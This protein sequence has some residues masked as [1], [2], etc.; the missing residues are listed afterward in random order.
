M[1]MLFLHGGGDAQQ[2]RSAIFGRFVQAATV[3]GS[4]RLA[5]VVAEDTEAQAHT[6]FE[7]YRAIFAALPITPIHIRPLFISAAQP[8]T[9]AQL[10]QI[11]P[12]GVFV[13]G[14]STIS[15]CG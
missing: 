14:G 15:R 4:C 5:L 9:H 2:A 10:E 8:L 1:P 11:E 7:D 13:C 3:A 6:S 12:S